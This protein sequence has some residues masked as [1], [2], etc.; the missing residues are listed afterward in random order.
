MD[1]ELISSVCLIRMLRIIR[2]LR[3]SLSGYMFSVLSGVELLGP[4]VVL[5]LTF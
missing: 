5:C 2:P 3:N 4:K 1:I